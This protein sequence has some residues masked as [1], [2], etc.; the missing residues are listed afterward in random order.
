MNRLPC[1][2]QVSIYMY[3]CVCMYV[4]Y[5]YV[6]IYI[7]MCVNFVIIF[8]EMNVIADLC[9]TLLVCFVNCCLF[10]LYAIFQYIYYVYGNKV[11]FYSILLS[12]IYNTGE[13][14]SGRIAIGANP[15]ICH[16]RILHRGEYSSKP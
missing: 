10:T 13:L 3:V 4:Y 14:R 15:P 5:V 6:D 8:Y 9:M 16:G 7:Y 11:I 1:L 2:G 12:F